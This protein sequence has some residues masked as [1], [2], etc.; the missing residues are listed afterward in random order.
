MMPAG[1]RMLTDFF[2]IRLNSDGTLDTTFGSSETRGRPY[3]NHA[4]ITRTAAGLGLPHTIR[5]E[6]RPSKTE[7][8]REKA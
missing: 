5:R 3:G 8:A 7:R 6:G 4:W 2:V 1:D